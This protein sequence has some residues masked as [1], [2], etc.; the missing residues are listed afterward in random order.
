MEISGIELL[1]PDKQVEV[2]LKASL[3]LTDEQFKLLKV[4]CIINILGG[5]LIAWVLLLDNSIQ[6]DLIQSWLALFSSIN[7]LSFVFAVAYH[8]YCRFV[9]Q[10]NKWRIA[11]R[12]VI[13]IVSLAW[14][15]MYFLF[16]P[17][18]PLA[19]F[20]LIFGVF[21]ASSA[22]AFGTAV[23]FMAS[24]ISIVCLLGIIILWKFYLTIAHLFL[25]QSNFD[26]LV[27]WQAFGFMIYAFF[28]VR[29]SWDYY[30]LY[31]ESVT[32]KLVNLTLKEEIGVQ[33]AIVEEQKIELEKTNEILDQKVKERTKELESALQ[34]VTYLATYDNLT[35]LPN[36]SKLLDY[37][38]DNMREALLNN[39]R[40]G[41]VCFTIKDLNSIVDRYGYSV[42]N[43]VV[44]VIAA[45]LKLKTVEL[46]TAQNLEYKIAISRRD[47]F[48]ILISPLN[49][50]EIGEK[51]SDLFTILKTPI[52]IDSNQFKPD[53]YIGLCFYP[54]HGETPD[55]LLANAE[56]AISSAKSSV[57]AQNQ[58]A[59]YKSELGETFRYRL[60]LSH[61]LKDAL[62]HHEFFLEYQPVVDILKNKVVGVEALVRWKHPKFGLI[63][64]GTFIELAE[65][66]GLIVPLGEWV[67][68]KACLDMQRLHEA[69]F[70]DLWVAVNL[71]AIQIKS[72]NL[73]NA[74][75]QALS[76]T[77][78]KPEYLELELTETADFSHD[79]Q[80][81]STFRDFKGMGI[82]LS[83]DDFGTKNSNLD[84]V[85]AFT[86]DKIKIDGTFIRALETDSNSRVI[87]NYCIDLAQKLRLA[88]L[89]ECVENENQL[90]YLKDKR[91]YLIQG[92]YFSKPLD[93]EKLL[94]FLQEHVPEIRYE[95][96]KTIDYTART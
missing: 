9:S 83:I 36:H 95:K 42:A 4:G 94:V 69:G 20:C 15:S 29:G 59:L 79:E 72:A 76:E 47:D 74:V 58:I 35:K 16:E 75:R 22:I 44:E 23:D 66:N 60:Q 90:N 33:K 13:G 71:S 14:S 52:V 39:T 84:H 3:E 11:Y 81:V 50:T 32:K 41:I 45:R 53:A 89:A 57:H 54:E 5:I 56:A 62:I 26:L 93:K 51:V 73:M 80:V 87:V 92:F 65:Q 21:A 85:K 28:L 64:P 96:L 1:K 12:F 10:V 77:R 88:I 18:T 68:Y 55:E 6:R 24:I 40:F 63:A 38:K 61:D 46:S 67:L 43:K 17:V 30:K 82:R 8:K 25:Y 37:I 31:K 70:N 91:C 27:I 49:E 34:E 7:I 86:V 19:Q 2:K 78:L 48:F